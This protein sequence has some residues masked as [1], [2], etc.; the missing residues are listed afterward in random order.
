MFYVTFIT[1]QEKAFLLDSIQAD[2]WQLQTVKSSRVGLRAYDNKMYVI[3]DNRRVCYGDP[4][5][6]QLSAC[7]PKAGTSVVKSEQRVCSKRKWID[8]GEGENDLFRNRNKV[9]KIA[10]KNNNCNQN[11]VKCDSNNNNM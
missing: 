1:K 5:Q 7:Q 4:I 3:D 10:F 11:V 6:K 8:N 9:L 2:K